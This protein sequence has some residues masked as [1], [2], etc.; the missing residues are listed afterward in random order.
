MVSNGI[1]II[2]LLNLKR[3]K[4]FNSKRINDK[5]A[6]RAIIAVLRNA[7]RTDKKFITAVSG[8]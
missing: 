6:K 2:Y 7:S 4:R 8:A 5:A 1:L 3:V